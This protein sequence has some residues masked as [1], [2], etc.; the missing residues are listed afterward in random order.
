MSRNQKVGVFLIVAWA[1]VFIL[2]GII[3][4]SFSK[5]DFNYNKNQMK[6]ASKKATYVKLYNVSFKINDDSTIIKGNVSKDSRSKQ[7]TYAFDSNSG[8]KI[9]SPKY[10][11]S[12]YHIPEYTSQFKL[13]NFKE[14]SGNDNVLDVS[15]YVDKELMFMES[16][17]D[18]GQIVYTT[19]SFLIGT[20]ILVI[21]TVVI[22]DMI[23]KRKK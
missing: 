3:G 16:L 9:T 19:A 20:V 7:E 21:P 5:A 10:E 2:S 15:D 12:F 17:K 11:V 13:F 8:F 4:N 22:N 6:M 18:T 1:I 14:V 23:E